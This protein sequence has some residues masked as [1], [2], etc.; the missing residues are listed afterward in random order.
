MAGAVTINSNLAALNAQ[1]YLTQNSKALERSLAHLSSGLR[2]NRAADDAAGLAISESL[3]VDSLVFNQGIRNVNDGIS[4][5][6]IAEGAATELDNILIRMRELATQAS[7]GTYS[8]TQRQ[9]QDAEVQALSREY[10]RVVSTAEFNGMSIFDTGLPPITIQ[11]GYGS[12]QNLTAALEQSTTV[13]IPPGWTPTGT[14]A[15]PVSYPGAASNHYALSAADFNGDGKMDLADTETGTNSVGLYLGNAN[16]TFS[17]RVS[18]VTDV[19]PVWLETADVDGDSKADVV[20]IVGNAG[21]KFD[22]F[23]GNGDGTFKAR[24]SFNGPAGSS[25]SEFVFGNFNGDS[26]PDIAVPDTTSN[27]VAIYTNS[28]GGSFT[29]SGSC[30]GAGSNKMAVG[31]FNGDGKT[32]LSQ[33]RFG[34]FLSNGNGTF[35]AL[36]SYAPWSSNIYSTTAADINGDSK[37][38]ILL[39][40]DDGAGHPAVTALLGNGN[41][42]FQVRASYT[43]GFNVDDVI[44]ADFNGDGK[45]DIITCEGNDGKVSLFLGNGNGTFAARR[46]STVATGL[47]SGIAVDLNGDSVLDIAASHDNGSNAFS[48]MLANSTITPGSS[49]TA[50][51]CIEPIGGLSIATRAA[52]LS[53]QSTID[54]Y[55]EDVTSVLGVIGASQS[56]FQ[57]TISNMQ[58]LTENLHSAESRITDTDIAEETA[59]L[60]KTQILQQASTAVLAQ[61]NQ[62]PELALLLLRG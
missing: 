31:D 21:G 15:A 55:L 26:L 59:Q 56:R 10:N 45:V 38:D 51:I 14:Y 25:P 42:T 5:L 52:A 36:I 22:I 39:G 48:V 20:V 58:G 16:G 35:G 29:Y 34:V 4:Y 30:S 27:S 23:L 19:S 7:N 8:D 53:A 57:T 17:A 62:A 47:R 9:A 60:V 32:D 13:I 41:G 28:G 6:N 54:G 24:Y 12:A 37:V 43:A 3:K 50:I 44:S 49:S 40:G 1:R 18:L 33:A 11:A 2:I 61:A 46:S